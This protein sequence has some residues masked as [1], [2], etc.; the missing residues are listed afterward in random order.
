MMFSL[1]AMA[2][3][4]VKGT[5]VDEAGQPIIGATVI[6][7]GS[8]TGTT[9][10]IDGQFALPVPAEGVLQISYIGYITETIS[11]MTKTEVVLKEDHQNI[12]EVVVVGYGTQKKAHLTGSVASVP[13]EEIQD[14]SNGNLSNALSG[15]INGIS[16][17]GGEARPGEAA[18][19]YVRNSD[20]TISNAQ[21]PLYVIDGFILDAEA[22]NNL[23]PS[24]VES[25]SVLKDA[26]AAVYGS[27]A[28]GGVIL[29]TTK[30]GKLGAPQ[31][32]YNGT[33]GI[34]DAVAKPKMLSTYNY[35]R[36]YNAVRMGD[37][38]ELGINPTFDIFQADELQAMKS[39]NYD[40]LDKYWETAV[41]HQHSL[42]LSGA[43]EAASYFANI[44]YFN[45]DGNLG[46]LDYERWNFR[47]GVDL[48]ITK[49]LKASLQV[50]GNYGT[51]NKPLMKVQSSSAER[52]YMMLLSH[53]QYIPEEING[54]PLAAYGVS[55][56][57][58]NATQCYNYGLLQN[59]SDYMNNMTSN[60]YVNGALSYD[61][62]WSRILKGLNLRLSYSKAIS[63]SKSN[64]FGTQFNLYTLAER[65]GSGR[66]LYTPMPGE[67]QY[68]NEVILDGGNFQ[69]AHGGPI[70]NG[71]GDGYVQRT[72]SRSD[73]YQLNFTVGYAR[74]FGKHSVNA[75]FSIEKTESESENVL[76]QGTS[77]YEFSTGQ[78]NSLQTQDGTPATSSTWARSESGTLSYVGRV[79]YAYDDKYLLEFLIRSDA[80]TKFAPENYWGYFPSL[81]AGWVV[82]KESW[83][84]DNVK[85]VDFLKLRA[86]FGLTGRDNI[87]AWQWK[88][89]YD[90]T[91][92]KGG[93]LGWN[94]TAGS[95]IQQ[96]STVNRDV[97][98]DK[99]YKGNIGIDW[100]LLNNRLG[101]TI[102]GYYVWD[103]EMLM[104]FK[105][106]IPGTV[107]A[108][109]ASQNYGEMD[110]YGVEFAATWRD[111][112]GKDF[113]Y[114]IG[115]NTGY[116]D[117][118][119]LLTEW[120][121]EQDS[122][123]KVQKNGRTDV[124]TWGMQCI[125]MF[126]SFQD[127]EEY[128]EQYG[129]DTYMG[130]TKDRVRPGMLIYKD[131]RG[132]RLS[133]G[134]F[135]GP[136]GVVNES[137]DRVRLSNRSNP[138]NITLNLNAEWKGLALTAQI[139]ASWGGYSMIPSSALKPT[140]GTNS[141]WQNLEY[142]NMPSFW[143]PDNM[144][145]YED[146]YDGSNNLV[147]AANRDASLPNMRYADV[148]SVGSSFWRVSGTRVTLNRLTLAYSLPKKWLSP[149]G[150]SAA[151]VNVTGQNLL[152]FYNPYPDNFID[153]M[154]GYGAYP[155]LRKFTIGL[156]VTF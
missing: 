17:S 102:E 105:G 101:F 84:A 115:I 22:F 25:I 16:V 8:T 67:E 134:T 103:R 143:N 20:E 135:E 27:R 83:F 24:S 31:I 88:Q 10:G 126:R 58:I 92:D 119:V 46:K 145:V 95:H 155:T 70:T 146:I 61:F 50:S 154:M 128:F 89:T 63:T 32:S 66:H 81:S 149:I 77:P 72:M 140:D 93:V 122:Y 108:G 69:Q 29:V 1:T 114:K 26:S 91:G 98:W 76:A 19:I 40:L 53:P 129:I 41:T 44:A 71:T 138:Y 87:A 73:N 142:I 109:T 132:S 4:T 30:K 36:L 78:S 152:S 124:G 18:T 38:K 111:K 34:T 74:D 79:N 28:A 96:G 11:D 118:K 112:I 39:L 113:K 21:P 97:H 107:G 35:G 100:N 94:G 37:P 55:G 144:F 151:R 45:Q 153:P 51:Q 156:N 86:S 75:L 42:N 7:K 116:S 2:Q 139:G 148:N 136:N 82:S 68:Y 3:Q 121:T 130:M 54:N 125:G 80:S 49:H 64:E 33:I 48:K 15:L 57:E 127:I 147:M 12:E 6:V 60:T 65:T 85:W 123:M 23:D 52:D 131:I 110:S 13:M 117:N 5:V 14:I 104:A 56:K 120:S 133:D 137:E 9:T 47:A 150:I 99:S 62:G 43:T 141:G 106:S 59:S 90:V